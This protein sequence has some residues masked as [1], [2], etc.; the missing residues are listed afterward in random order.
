M[1]CKHA[2]K[3]FFDIIYFINV[4]CIAIYNHSNKDIAIIIIAIYSLL[5]VGYAI[6][7]ALLLLLFCS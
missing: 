4:T 3:E 1:H 2:C 7:L 6:I 5:L